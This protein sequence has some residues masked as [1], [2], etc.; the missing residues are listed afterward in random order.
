MSYPFGQAWNL[1][2]VSPS[3]STVHTTCL[4]VWRVFYSGQ[5][6]P[7]NLGGKPTLIN[8]GAEAVSNAKDAL[9]VQNIIMQ[10]KLSM[11]KGLRE[12]AQEGLEVCPL[13]VGVEQPSAVEHPSHSF[14][15]ILWLKD[16][17]K[18]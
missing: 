12:T 13:L 3:L 15:A 5:W 16:Q 18:F 6:V 11:A 4:E 7:D 8:N 2:P 10:A 14:L 17:T 1:V 9:E